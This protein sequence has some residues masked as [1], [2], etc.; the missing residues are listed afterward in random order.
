MPL[1]K[2][3][4]RRRTLL[5]RR[6]WPLLKIDRNRHVFAK[7][8]NIGFASCVNDLNKLSQQSVV[9]AGESTN[10]LVLSLHRLDNVPLQSVRA[11]TPSSCKTA[12]QDSL[13]PGDLEVHRLWSHTKADNS[14]P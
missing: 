4:L 7:G 6:F 8:Q 2:S 10:R 13:P 11:K 3:Q 5:G 12:A 9:I 1:P 14:L